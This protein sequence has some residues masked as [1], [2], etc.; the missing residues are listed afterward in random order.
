MTIGSELTTLILGATPISE[1][2][3]AILYGIAAGL[4][5]WAAYFL[6]L[7][8]NIIPLI[9]A[10]LLLEKGSQWL[11]AVS[12]TMRRF[13]TWLFARVQRKHSAH[14]EKWGLLGL[15]IFV[16]IPLP[17]TGAW[18]GAVAAFIFGL[19]RWPAFLMLVLG[20]AAAG[21]IVL[22]TVQTGISIFG[23]FS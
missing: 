6:G 9:P 12:P 15:F 2:R 14:F 23:T 20:A 10:L 11:S 18:S 4:H 19:R 22:G 1:I 16:A 5:P 21:L 13:F 8:G 7:L 17:M 3:G